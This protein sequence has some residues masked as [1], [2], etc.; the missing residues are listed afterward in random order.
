MNRVFYALADPYL[1]MHDARDNG[2][3]PMLNREV[4][5]YP[6]TSHYAGLRASVIGIS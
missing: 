4:G 2:P 6:F 5:K 3:T 1:H